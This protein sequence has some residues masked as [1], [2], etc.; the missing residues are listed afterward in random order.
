MHPPTS[1]AIHFQYYWTMLL[2]K[3]Y[4]SKETTFLVSQL[5][6]ESEMYFESSLGRYDIIITGG[7]LEQTR[8][9]TRVNMP[10]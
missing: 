4:Y 10:V 3:H 9:D 7:G 5:I 8:M 6:F 2:L 1:P